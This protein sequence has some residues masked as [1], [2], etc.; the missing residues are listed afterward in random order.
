M[1][2]RIDK[3]PVGGALDAPTLSVFRAHPFQNGVA[4]DFCAFC[5]GTRTCEFSRIGS[6]EFVHPEQP[7]RPIVRGQHG[8]A[9]SEQ[10]SW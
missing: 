8:I 6:G 5:D 9:I 7:V 2:Q 3:A 4:R 10:R 1:A